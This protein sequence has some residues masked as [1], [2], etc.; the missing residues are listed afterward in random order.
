MVNWPVLLSSAASEDPWQLV[1]VMVESFY[2]F[3][4]KPL[5]SHGMACSAHKYCICMQGREY[6]DHHAVR[7]AISHV[8]HPSRRGN[9]AC[10]TCVHVQLPRTS[11]GAA[12]GAAVGAAPTAQSGTSS[13]E[14]P[15]TNTPH[16]SV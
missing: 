8:S 13:K 7:A 4:S 10:T 16:V 15:K 2:V 12:V 9:A 5:V 14:M 6:V 1:V 11:Y 3:A